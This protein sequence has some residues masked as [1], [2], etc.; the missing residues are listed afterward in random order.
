MVQIE[1]VRGEVRVTVVKTDCKK[2]GLIEWKG[3]VGVDCGKAGCCEELVFTSACIY[4]RV[5][6]RFPLHTRCYF[7]FRCYI[8]KH[9]I[10][11]TFLFLIYTSFTEAATLTTLTITFTCCLCK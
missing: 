4:T 9:F 7:S 8:Y 11:T 6:F 3:K 1:C 2:K 5:L 10:L